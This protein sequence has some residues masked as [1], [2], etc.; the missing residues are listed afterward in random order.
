[1]TTLRQQIEEI[2]WKHY[3]GGA[4]S[5]E[6]ATD[7]IMQVVEAERTMEK[8]GWMKSPDLP[9]MS[10]GI[11]V[12]SEKEG[13]EERFDKFMIDEYGKWRIGRAEVK[14]FIRSEIE[15][16]LTLTNNYDHPRN[17]RGFQ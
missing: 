4:M 8:Q 5:G 6:D 9:T 15:G 7:E 17:H 13:W 10:I 1:M 16:E 11:N 2:I 3:H 12:E 14:S